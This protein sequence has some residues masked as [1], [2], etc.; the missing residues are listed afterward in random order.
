MREPRRE[1]T[2]FAQPSGVLF[3]RKSRSS[4]PLPT[5][6]ALLREAKA[7]RTAFADFPGVHLV[8]CIQLSGL[9]PI[10]SISGRRGMDAKEVSEFHA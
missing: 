7:D 3:A 1:G 8:A 5:M 9:R 6:A 2:I 10:G 4:P